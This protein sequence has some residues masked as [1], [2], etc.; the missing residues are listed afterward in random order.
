MPG[1]MLVHLEH[2][3][4]VLAEDALELVVGQDLAAVL[5]VLQVVGLDVVPHLTHHLASGQRS[6]AD[7][8]GQRFGRLQRPLQ[9]VRLAAA[10]GGLLLR[11]LLRCPGWHRSPPIRTAILARAAPGAVRASTGMLNALCRT[12]ISGRSRGIAKA[13]KKIAVECQTNTEPRI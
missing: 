10:C 6:W 9:R 1:E 3:H 5:R 4:L 7:H 11:R 12:P 2:G 13:E 8:R